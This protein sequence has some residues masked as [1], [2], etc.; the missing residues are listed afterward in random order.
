MLLI[1]KEVHCYY[2]A[3]G[4]LEGCQ[5][6]LF[7]SVHAASHLNSDIAENSLLYIKGPFL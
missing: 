3:Q 2:Q 7:H 5:S 6:H 1:I 4:S